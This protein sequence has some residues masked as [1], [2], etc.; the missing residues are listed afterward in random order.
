MHCLKSTAWGSVMPE[1]HEPFHNPVG[2][3]SIL[4]AKTETYVSISIEAVNLLREYYI[5]QYHTACKN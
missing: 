3:H 5:Q 2:Y 4:T 1:T